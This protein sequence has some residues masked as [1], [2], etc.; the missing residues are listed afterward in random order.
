MT[1]G[2]QKVT[3]DNQ[4]TTKI[5]IGDIDNVDR[6]MLLLIKENPK[7]SQ[8]ELGEKLNLS[9]TTIQKRQKN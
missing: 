2:D 5:F 1:K 8:R 7:I 3:I 9:K 6:K 4:I